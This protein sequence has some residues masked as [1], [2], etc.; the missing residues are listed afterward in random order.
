MDVG[1]C[2]AC[3]S[4]V[5][6]AA[7][8]GDRQLEARA[9]RAPKGAAMHTRSLSMALICAATLLVGCGGDDDAKQADA[10]ADTARPQ[11]VAGPSIPRNNPS[12]SQT[13]TA[14]AADPIGRP[15]AAGAYA[16]DYCQALLDANAADATL[17]RKVR[18]PDAERDGVESLEKYYVA[19]LDAARA[20]AIE[21]ATG[22]RSA[23]SPRIAAGKELAADVR[24]ALDYVDLVEDARNDLDALATK[25]PTT[26][27]ERAAQIVQKL[28][29][30]I[31]AQRAALQKA[32]DSAVLDDAV[33]ASTL[34]RRLNK[35]D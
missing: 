33:D 17:R 27:L 21:I 35:T 20:S 16:E 32:P 24:A 28:R 34:C 10:P 7:L 1:R 5:K 19:V 12:P 26:Y 8:A 30:D 6:I 4:G 3:E 22:L 13:P 23:G 14:K 31:R 15:V 11:T 2:S 18:A 29:T 9:V 25:R